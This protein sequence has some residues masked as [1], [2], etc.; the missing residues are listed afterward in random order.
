MDIRSERPRDISILVGA[1]SVP[2]VVIAD[3]VRDGV[4]DLAAGG[5]TA[6][7][8]RR[9]ARRLAPALA[10]PSPEARGRFLAPY[11]AE[12]RFFLCHMNGLGPLPEAL[13]ESVLYP[14]AEGGVAALAR[15]FPN[16]RVR[17]VIGIV[18]LA[19]FFTTAGGA[20][21]RKIRRARWERLYELSWADR[22]EMIR[23]IW[24]DA[25]VVVLTPAGAARCSADLAP[26]LFGQPLGDPMAFL[27]AAVTE[28]GRAALARGV[29]PQDVVRAHSLAP[30]PA[31]LAARG[32]DDSLI[33]LLEDRYREDCARMA[34]MSGVTIL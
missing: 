8:Q 26:L 19:R 13:D 10:S 11:G 17:L 25:D 12:G 6:L 3:L 33:Q 27:S 28:N 21:A 20:L 22:V 30:D 29:D 32:I 23:A 4:A 9:A 1:H 2:S 16:D 34:A 18:P 5:L 15:L 24:P 14:G 7:P 31:I